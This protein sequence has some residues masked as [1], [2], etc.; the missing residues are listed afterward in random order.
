[1]LKKL[2]L[3]RPRIKLKKPTKA[4]LKSTKLLVTILLLSGTVLFAGSA[5]VWYK[6]IFSDTDRVFY[7]M[8][9]NSL[10]T[11]SVTRTVTQSE[12][13]RTIDQ[14]Y[15]M[16]FTPKT[17]IESS[18]TIEQISPDRSKSSVTTRTIGQQDTDFVQYSDISIPPSQ[19]SGNSD[20]SKVLNQWAKR[21]KNEETGEQAQFLNEAIFTFIPFG[22]FSSENRD[23]LVNMIREKKV[24][25]LSNPSVSYQQGRPIMDVTVS[26]KPKA[27]IEVLR[28]YSIMSGI[29]DKEL[30]NP[31]D[32]ERAGNVGV[33]IK[34]DMLSRHLTEISFPGQTRKETYGSYG[35]NRNI[36]VP[37]Q[38]ISV[39]ELQGR[40]QN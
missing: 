8:I 9:D 11:E 1:M 34:I 23:V 2:S 18:S 40:L 29:G 19:N 30:L 24:Y 20:F 10:G 5:Y 22:N 35:L 6:N 4:G 33:Q 31:A 12:S 21:Q 14:T 39:E 3:R 38:T 25:T 15:Y 17:L 36:V 37:T 32:Y 26:I 7:G 13:S 28:E 16:A 27:L